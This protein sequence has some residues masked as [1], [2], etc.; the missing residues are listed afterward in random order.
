MYKYAACSKLAV[1][2][3]TATEKKFPNIIYPKKDFI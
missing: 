1:I 2:V 3:I